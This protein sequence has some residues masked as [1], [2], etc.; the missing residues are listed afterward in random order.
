MS[1]PEGFPLEP[2][3]PDD[4]LDA[5]LRNG[6]L[7]ALVSARTPR[8]YLEDP[9]VGRLFENFA[10][11]ERDYF[12]RTR[13]FPI[14]H[15]LGVRRDV[16]ERHPWLAASL[17]KAFNQAK[18]IAQEELTQTAALKIGLPWVVTEALATRQLMGE[19]FWP[20]GVE[21]N[22]QVLETLTR[23]AHEQGLSTRPVSVEELFA[24]N[25][26]TEPKL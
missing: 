25:T 12:A 8:A 2:I 1:L 4:T 22:R 17:L 21:A 5:M 23:Y 9:N 10:E 24:P 15:A 11:V 7:D 26:L 19:D 16:H 18:A 6:E 3:G 14:M 13:L 20:Y